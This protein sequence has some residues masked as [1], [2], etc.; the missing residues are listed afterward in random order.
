MLAL[1]T[2]LGQGQGWAASW[3]RGAGATGP[4]WQGKEMSRTPSEHCG[5]SFPCR[6]QPARV[7][8]CPAFSTAAVAAVE[9]SCA[10]G[11][12]SPTVLAAVELSHG[13]GPAS[14]GVQDKWDHGQCGQTVPVSSQ[15]AAWPQFPL[16]VLT[17]CVGGK[18]QPSEPG[19]PASP[20]S[21]SC[22]SCSAWGGVRCLLL[23]P[24]A[25]WLCL[26]VC[27]LLEPLCARPCPAGL[28]P[29][30]PSARRRPGEDVE[31]ALVHPD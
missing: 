1:R 2:A 12:A 20:P 15:G 16:A 14:L 30:L 21:S 6:I 18:G 4:S 11:P 29:T 23:L 19:S 27:V 26:A 13:L 5:S 10:Q 25:A 3:H 22:A 7:G 17:L 24:A 9:G 8:A 31:A 28:C